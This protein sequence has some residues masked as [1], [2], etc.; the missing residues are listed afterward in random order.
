MNISQLQMK[1][2]M[3][4]PL[5]TVLSYGPNRKV[6]SKL[7]VSIF[8]RPGQT[9]PTAVEKWLGQGQ[10]I[11]Q[12]PVVM[13][14]V[15]EFK[16]RHFVVQTVSDARVMGCPHQEGIDY[17]EGQ[18]CPQCPFWTN[19]DRYTLEPKSLDRPLTPDQILAGLS[20]GRDAQPMASLAA[21]EHHRQ[22]LV[23]PFILAVERALDHPQDVPP[24]DAQLFSYALAFLA[25][26]REP[27][28]FQLVL[29]W[30]SLPGEGAFDLGGDT[31]T[32][33]GS[34]LLALTCGGDPTLIKHLIQN[35]EANEFCRGQA[36]E[37]LALLVAG[38]QL[39][40]LEI[41]D[42]FGWLAREGLE[43]EFCTAWDSLVT[44]SL[45]IE[46]ITA[47]KDLRR[48]GEEELID[49]FILDEL[50]EVE[51]APRGEQ[52]AS[53]RR[54]FVPFENIAAET[55]WWACF[56]ERGSDDWGSADV[57]VAEEA[58]FLEPTLDDYSAPEPYIAPPKIGRNEPCPCGSGKKFKKCCG[59]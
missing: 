30:L 16:A 35:R 5:A 47:F 2:G 33:W 58:Q 12:D 25:K 45:D 11:R 19:L 36:I 48:A 1:T 21:A 50:D 49:P 44:A 9:E 23:E 38:N 53:F 3:K 13:A 7:V 37:A 31:V 15:N 26:W 46:A 59:G 42:Y 18:E 56:H 40:Q 39:T 32:E 24:D 10:D 43:R 22:R 27:R 8:H 57:D 17:P 51:A 34:R 20:C 41:A 4:Y 55:I 29:R 52:I 14:A 28:A 54:H 6:A